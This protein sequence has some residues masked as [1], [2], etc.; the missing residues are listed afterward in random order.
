MNPNNP[1]AEKDQIAKNTRIIAFDVRPERLGYVVLEGPARL[2]D[3]DVTRFISGVRYVDRVTRL[4]SFF[5]PSLVVL[6]TIEKGGCR[7]RPS[8]HKIVRSISRRLHSIGVPI[9]HISD[10]KVKRTFRQCAEPTK[11]EI[12][13]FLAAC[14]P[15]LAWQ[16]PPRR[17]PWQPEDRRMS[18]F[19][20]AALG[21]AY[22]AVI[23]PDSVKE[24]IAA[25]KSFRRPL[26]GAA[27]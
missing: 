22:F 14:F 17:R 24:F 6:R 7:D 10:T 11:D 4:A 25:A 23:D 27:I 12:A 9:A 15:E 20:A 13:K 2:V 26:D 5:Q 8:L 18:V 3:W 19:D 1:P 21:L 16:L